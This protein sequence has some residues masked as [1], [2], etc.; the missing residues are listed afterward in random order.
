MNTILDFI[1]KQAVG[2]SITVGS[3]LIVIFFHRVHLFANLEAQIF[4]LAFR[5][6]GPLS[7][8][9]AKKPIPKDSES[10]ADL[11]DNGQ[12]DFEEP[13][14]DVGNGSWD[15]GESFDDKNENGQWD[16]GE[17]YS[18]E[19]NG[20]WDKGLDVVLI[21]LDQK[22]YEN[23]PW[24]WPYTREVWALVL[25]NLARAG[26]RVVVFDIQFDAPDRLAEEPALKNIRG[27][28]IKEGLR[29]LIP[30][31]G[32]SVFAE[33]INEAKAM[34]TSVVLA[35]KIG[36]NS[37]E[38]RS[39]L[40][41]PNDVILSASPE[42]AL[43]DETQ[44]PDGTTRRYYAFN[45]LPDEPDKWY[46]TLAMRA[47]K[48]FQFFPDNFR[49]EGDSEQGQILF[50]NIQIPTYG[51]SAT[52]Y[53]NYY[54]PPSAATS[55]RLEDQWKTFTSYPLYY[56]VDVAE[57]DLRNIE[58]DSNWM[59][60][61]MLDSEMYG[62]AGESPFK[63]KIALI[64]VSVEVFHDTKHT[65]YFSF[66]GEQ[67]LMPGVEVHANALQT[68]LDQ[69]FISIYGGDMEWSEKSWLYHVFLIACLSLIAYV[70]LSAMNPLVAGLCIIM[71]LLI[72]VS[73]AIGAFTADSLWLTKLLL[74]RWHT[75]NVPGMGQSTFVPVVA[76]IFGVFATYI[77]NVLYRFIVEQKDKRFL[78]STFGT[79]VSPELIDRMYEEHQEPKLGGEAGYHTAFFSDIQSFSAFSEVLEPER[80][81][82]LMNEYL[83]EMTDILLA[84]RGTLDKYI[85]DAIVA[86]Y[87]APVPVEDHELL[88]CQTALDMEARLVELRQKWMS[89]EEWPDIVHD[90]RHRVGL[91]SGNMVTGNM[92]SNMRMNY[93]MMGDTVNIAARLEASAKQY[94][95]YIQVAEN[96]Y[97][98]VKEEFEWRFLDNVRVKGK[99]RPVTVYE[100]LAEKDNLDEVHSKVVPIFHEGIDYYNNQKWK[101]AQAAFEEAE[102]L[103]DM[104][105]R[106][107]ANPSNIY[108]GR[109][110]FFKDNP[111]G[112]DWD[113]VWTLTA[114]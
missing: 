76:P 4:D 55:L 80:M 91:N 98:K 110:E 10:F 52:F 33:A 85:G 70:F 114:K 36:Y 11:N 64:G 29:E 13:F 112:D 62:F 50:E 19:G 58:D 5:V 75:I 27:E 16:Q 77:G 106:R 56:V 47:A 22:S 40:V 28:L 60:L 39:E 25:R 26:A 34:G 72:F 49:L 7:G 81:V 17:N 43:V 35:S 65:P 94:G 90:L 99:K 2:L 21:D 45:W 57:V 79:Y 71:E 61:F 84:R 67:K 104:F 89:E 15:E 18:D 63:N 48:E 24:S 97:E 69:N 32:D 44:D 100:L 31:H 54:G 41:L 102:K 38:R 73:V 46:L 105:S 8:L 51:K 3:V 86:F 111:P 107:P 109:C 101:K 87:G 88:A 82:A 9:G 92:G 113:G 12:W 93:T 53:I 103:E 59:E 66:A 96:T 68:I 78:K 1:K 37:L 95:V 20:L 30:T 83:T 108:V 42:T 23:V 6:R 14:N 74:G